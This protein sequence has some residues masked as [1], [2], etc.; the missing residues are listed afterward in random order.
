MT[1]LTFA[2]GVLKII[3]GFRIQQR[4]FSAFDVTKEFRAR[5]NS[6]EWELTDSQKELVDGS[7]TFRIDHEQVRG[8]I[9]SLYNNGLLTSYEKGYGDYQGI[10]FTLY[11][12]QLPSGGSTQTTASTSTSTSSNVL[13]SFKPNVKAQQ[14][15][16]P[17]LIVGYVSRKNA[18]G[19]KATLK[20]IQSRFKKLHLKISDIKQLVHSAGYFVRPV[21]G[22]K[23]SM[24][25]VG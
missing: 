25:V 23:P 14:P 5:V 21:A 15:N 1:Q 7:P 19:E 12:F 18:K 4:D 11:K 20:S 9:L 22:H 10:S 13:I 17:N 3:D 8:L 6:G 2:V 16:L 24:S